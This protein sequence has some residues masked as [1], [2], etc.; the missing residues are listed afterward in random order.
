MFTKLGRRMNE[1][2]ENFSKEIENFFFFDRKY[3]L[4]KLKNTVTN[5]KCTRGNQQQIRGCR[6]MD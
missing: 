2:S 4:K 6:R 3:F 1:L 5:E